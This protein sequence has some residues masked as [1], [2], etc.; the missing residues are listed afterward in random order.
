MEQFRDYSRNEK[1]PKVNDKSNLENL[2]NT[3]MTKLRLGNRPP[4]LPSE[5]KMIRD[6]DDLWKRLEGAEKDFL[7]WILLEL[8]KLERLDHLVAKFK[9]KCDIHESWSQGK[10]DF[11]TSDV[12]YTLG[13]PTLLAMRKKH[14]AFESDLTAQQDRV[15]QIVA[16]AQE[17]ANLQYS[18]IGEIEIRR[19]TIC[20]GWDTLSDLTMARS[21]KLQ[22][23]IEKAER[24]DNMWLEYAKRA[25]PFVN[26]LDGAQEDLLDVVIV[27][28]LEEIKD[29]KEAHM[30]FV[31]NMPAAKEEYEGIVE[32]YQQIQQLTSEENPYTHTECKDIVS[33]MQIVE[34]L[35]DTRAKKLTEVEG[36]QER[37][38]KLRIEFAT[39]ANQTAQ[40]LDQRRRMLNEI[41]LKASG[42]TL[43]G[44]LTSTKALLEEMVNFRSQIDQ[45]ENINE[46]VQEAM[47][48][49]NE[50]TRFSM[51]EI[52][53]NYEQGTVGIQ[54]T[55]NQIENQILM[56][57]SLNMSEGQIS[58]ITESFKYFDKDG[59]NKLD[60]NEFLQ[61]LMSLGHVGSDD[62]DDPDFVKIVQRVD[63]NNIGYVTLD[64]F[65]AYMQEENMQVDTSETVEDSFKVLAGDKP[66]ITAEELRRELPPEQA[67]YCIGKMPAY[68]GPD[69]V[70]GALDYKAFAS[71]LYGESDL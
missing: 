18:K 19:K 37:N 15:E 27:H 47:I 23:A 1:P 35:I 54:R 53:I 65:M 52:R 2:Y 66:Y 43:D 6:I 31:A 13:L 36:Q 55:I 61:C 57:D 69:A 59:S 60:Y 49:E 10:S 4:F 64:G 21:Q 63:P 28:T 62:M 24:L 42:G 51:E 56:R 46:R 41:N 3:I 14:E 71:A 48:F 33:K 22:D 67:E 40:L 26:W 20:D 29:L 11:L 38:E 39:L 25:S 30:K 16:I 5:G 58:E 50:H 34:E 70:E 45:L 8:R 9:H 17:L 12:S 7:K 32:I 44:M 68:M